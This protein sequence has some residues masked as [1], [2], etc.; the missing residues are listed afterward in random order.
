VGTHLEPLQGGSLELHKRVDYESLCSV[1][2]TALC[3]MVMLGTRA[4][5][6]RSPTSTVPN[7]ALHS[8]AVHGDEPSAYASSHSNVLVA[9]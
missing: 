2:G 6:K 3:K 9:L 5:R 8:D 7:A 4:L 1:R